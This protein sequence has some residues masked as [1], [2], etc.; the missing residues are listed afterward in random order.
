MT[1]RKRK[2]L[3]FNG[4]IIALSLWRSRSN[5][6]GF[7]RKKLITEERCSEIWEV[8]SQRSRRAESNK[9]SLSQRNSCSHGKDTCFGIDTPVMPI[10]CVAG[11][12]ILS[13][14]GDHRHN[15]SVR[16]RPVRNDDEWVSL[17]GGR[18]RD[19]ALGITKEPRERR[20]N[21]NCD[22]RQQRRRRRRRLIDRLRVHSEV[23]TGHSL[24]RRWVVSSGSVNK[25][26]IYLLWTASITLMAGDHNACD[27][28]ALASQ[29][30]CL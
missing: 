12:P 3:A 29:C 24:K 8:I 6:P 13:I 9:R 30:Q 21:A 25:K 11:N 2:A 23:K 1:E 14:H 10:S 16:P 15:C 28:R 4:A 22:L 19:R 20:S 17:N 7:A 26:R 27:S 18:E 5:L